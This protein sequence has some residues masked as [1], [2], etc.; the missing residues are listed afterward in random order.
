MIDTAASIITRLRLVSGTGSGRSFELWQDRVNIGRDPSNVVSLD[1]TTVSLH[2]AILVRA[3]DH[4]K[5]RDLIST[6]G[7]YINGERRTGAELHNGDVLR[8]GDVEMRYEEVRLPVAD[9]RAVPSQTALP[10][11]RQTTSTSPTRARQYKIIGADGRVYGPASAALVRE[12]ISQGLANAQTWVPAEGP[13]SWKRLADFS[14]FAEVLAKNTRS[15]RLLGTPPDEA[16]CDEPVKVGPGTDTDEELIPA[17]GREY[18]I[19]GSDGR[20]YGPADEAR[21]RK[22]I[23][24]GFANSQ[25]WVPAEAGGNWKQLGEFPEFADALVGIT[26]PTN[27]LG[28]PPKEARWEEPIK[29]GPGLE[30]ELVATLKRAPVAETSRAETGAE[31]RNVSAYYVGMFLLLALAG[32]VA[33]WWFDQWPFDARGPL[34]QYARNTE[35]YIYSDPDYAAAATAEDAKDY[36]AV[37]QNAR[38]LVSHYPNSSLAHYILGVAYGKLG[39][40]SDATVEFQQAIKLK[41]DYIDAWNNLGWAYSQ[42]GKFA[43]AV[44]AFQQLIKFGPNN[45]QIWSNLGGAQAG[46][47]HEA[48]A[49]AAYQM[50]I[51][52]KPDYADAHF[53]L[54]AAYANQGKLVDAVN[55]FQLAVKYKPDFPEA[56]FNLGVVS[57][58]QGEN[59]EAVIFFQKAINLRPNYAEAWRGLV[60]AYLALHQTDQAD[61]AARELRRLDPTKADQLA[62]ELGRVAPQPHAP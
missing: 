26:T 16:R 55:S 49:I 35:G 9:P 24:Q 19:V 15:T 2:H 30:P 17:S 13:G 44:D 54:G 61:E 36:T 41:P 27:L 46:Q 8:F 12:W 29:A 39:S 18:L 38:Q 20:T 28:T 42:S 10:L 59:N 22:W 5:V 6:N 33:A 45:P 4:Y 7:T 60:K 32:A 53:N 51:Q 37:L 57:S 31:R 47:G 40:Y 34:R 3:G 11:G 14:E 21:L 58:R 23:S 52:L 43:E 1:H 50:A 25:T 48:D 56:W 62:K